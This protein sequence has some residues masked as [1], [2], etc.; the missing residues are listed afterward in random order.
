MK[1]EKKKF[2]NYSYF[3]VLCYYQGLGLVFSQYYLYIY[4]NLV[5]RY[6]SYLHYNFYF[7]LYFTL[8]FF[9]ESGANRLITQEIFSNR[10]LEFEYAYKTFKSKWFT[11]YGLSNYAYINN[12]LISAEHEGIDIGAHNGYLALLVQYGLLFELAFLSSFSPLYFLFLLLLNQT[13]IANTFNSFH[14]Y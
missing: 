11:G 8:D 7:N 2:L 14:S 5:L 10:M 1:V 9:K 13:G 6:V 4:L 12:D 3:F